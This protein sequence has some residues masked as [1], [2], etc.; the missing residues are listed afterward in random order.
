MSDLF[1]LCNEIGVTGFLSQVAEFFSVH[2]VVNFKQCGL[3]RVSG[4]G[5]RNLE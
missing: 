4:V 2:S 3:N 1:L 5:E